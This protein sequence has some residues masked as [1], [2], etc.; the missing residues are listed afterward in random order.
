[1]NFYKCVQKGKDAKTTSKE[2]SLVEIYCWRERARSNME[3]KQHY[4]QKK[5]EMFQRGK[6]GLSTEKRNLQIAHR[7][8]TKVKAE[9][10]VWK[11]LL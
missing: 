5:G 1:M 3:I 4:N 9:M 7:E 10:L 2:F 11:F 8:I 6:L